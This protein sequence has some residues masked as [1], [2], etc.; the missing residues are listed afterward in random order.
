MFSTASRKLFRV[1]SPPRTS[2]FLK[3]C[4][5]VNLM[6]KTSS[7]FLPHS[8]EGRSLVLK[9]FIPHVRP[10]SKT[11]CDGTQRLYLPMWKNKKKINMENT[12][13]SWGIQ[14][15]T[16]ALTLTVRRSLTAPWRLL[17]KY[18]ALTSWDNTCLL[19]KRRVLS[20]DQSEEIKINL[21]PFLPVARLCYGGLIPT[22]LS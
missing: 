14:A 7:C 16:T 13:V 22:W 12:I 18:N 20:F 17:N 1:F 4:V 3:H 19:I 15:A 2:Q 6:Q 8:K 5:L 9:H 11:L 10:F 21:Q